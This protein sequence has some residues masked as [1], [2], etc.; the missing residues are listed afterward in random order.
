MKPLF[1]LEIDTSLP[2]FERDPASALAEA[3]GSAISW[4][5]THDVEPRREFAVHDRAGVRAGLATWRKK[6]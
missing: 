4:L 5:R 3:L 6:G 1:I 2:A